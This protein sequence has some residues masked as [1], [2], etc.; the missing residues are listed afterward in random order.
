LTLMMRPQT[1]MKD[2][3]THSTPRYS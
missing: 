3:H 2:E 1:T